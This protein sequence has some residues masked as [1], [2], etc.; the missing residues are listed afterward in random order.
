MQCLNV[1]K[2][3][4]YEGAIEMYL[5]YLEFNPYSQFPLKVQLTY[6]KYRNKLCVTCNIVKS[7]KSL[8]YQ[9]PMNQRILSLL[10]SQI[11]TIWS[12]YL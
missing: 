9:M 1:A 6:M 11:I 3:V 12:S 5:Q 8:F 10:Q 2:V 4:L 7:F